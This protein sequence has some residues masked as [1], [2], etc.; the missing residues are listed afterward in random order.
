MLK[1]ISLAMFAMLLFGAGTVVSAQQTL[2]HDPKRVFEANPDSPT[3]MSRCGM[4]MGKLEDSGY[5]YP[6]VADGNEILKW[7]KG[8]RDGKEFIDSHPHPVAAGTAM[9]LRGVPGATTAEVA[10]E[11]CLNEAELTVAILIPLPEPPTVRRQPSPF[12][13]PPLPAPLEFRVR[14]N[15]VPDLPPEISLEMW[16]VLDEQG[17]SWVRFVP[18]VNIFEGRK[19]EWLWEMPLCGATVWGIY[20]L[21][22]GGAAAATPSASPPP[23]AVIPKPPFPT[24]S[25][26][27]LATLLV[28]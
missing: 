1:Q 2:R 9:F 11:G 25:P 10:F 22:A 3:A 15:P 13:P 24:V 5:I 19:K 28:Q 14:L 20:S 8:C 12:E 23:V 26:A 7:I 6:Y 27:R 4:T 21:A 18:C 17:R 16:V